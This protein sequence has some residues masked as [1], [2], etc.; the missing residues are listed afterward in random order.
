MIWGGEVPSDF[1]E[2]REGIEEPGGIED[3]KIGDSE[4]ELRV[5]D[6]ANVM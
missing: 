4:G 1:K 5:N 3:D 6:G 2:G